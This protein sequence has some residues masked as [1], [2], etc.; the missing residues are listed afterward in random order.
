MLQFMIDANATPIYQLRAIAALLLQ[1]ADS[2]EATGEES[3][4]PGPTG[5]SPAEVFG[6]ANRLPEAFAPNPPASIVA[7][8]AAP[9]PSNVVTLA[10]AAPPPP[11]AIVAPPA[12]AP[13]AA[14]LPGNVETDKAGVPYDARIHSSSRARVADGTWKKRRGGP[15]DTTATPTPPAAVVTEAPRM[16]SSASVAGSDAVGAAVAAAPPPPPAVQHQ[17]VTGEPNPTPAGPTHRSIMK[18]IGDAVAVGKITA[19]KAVELCKSVGVPDL[20]T[21]N[22]MPGKIPDVDALVDAFLMGK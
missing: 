15:K 4:A 18:K 22:S 5:D 3:G 6:G 19:E 10:V 16:P 1:C 17:L 7:P 13:P 14:V 20:V 21:L 12:A 11:A 2:R 8:P 9:P